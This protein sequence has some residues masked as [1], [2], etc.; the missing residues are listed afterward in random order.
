MNHEF[1]FFLSAYQDRCQLKL[2]I[3]IKLKLHEA[4]RNISDTRSCLMI[5]QYAIKRAT[6]TLNFQ[7]SLKVGESNKQAT[8]EMKAT[9]F[10]KSDIILTSWIDVKKHTI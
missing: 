1:S 5:N 9:I 3:E 10:D 8:L 2:S 6:R 4:L 7:S